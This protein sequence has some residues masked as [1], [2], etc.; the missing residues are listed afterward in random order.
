MGDQA[1]TRERLLRAA[2]DVLATEGERAIRVRDIAAQAGVTEPSLYHFFG[3]REGLITEAQ[4][5][6]FREEHLE[7]MQRFADAVDASETPEDF[8]AAVRA[9]LTWAYRPERRAARATRIDVLGSAQSRPELAAQLAAA[10]RSV[11]DQLAVTLRYAKARGWARQDVDC[12]ILAAWIIG[13]ITG[14]VFIEIDPEL[15]DSTEWD[16]ISITAVL[17]AFGFPP[18]GTDPGLR[19]RTASAA[20]DGGT[21]TS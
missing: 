14:R 5:T 8:A 10:Q 9:V 1:D 3:S 11:N 6:R 12:N 20:A 13:Q 21:L 16:E 15:A 7:G 19:S 17:A 2:I 4:A 18:A